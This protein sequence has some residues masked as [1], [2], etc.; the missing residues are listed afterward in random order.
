MLL[1]AGLSIQADQRLEA[2][3]GRV[4]E[5]AEVFAQVAMNLVNLDET[6]VH[7][8]FEAVRREAG[9][10]GVRVAGSELIGLVPRRTVEQARAAGVRIDSLDPSKVLET[11]LE[12]AGF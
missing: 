9:R 7:V 3:L 4:A 5:E 2:I 6:P 8:A 11:R 10:Y 12:Q 1:L